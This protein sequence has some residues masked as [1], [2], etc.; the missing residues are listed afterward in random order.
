MA[1]EIT[2]ALAGNP[3]SGKTTVF[4]NLTGAHQHVGNWPGKTVEKKEGVCH[5]QGYRIK[6]VDL[7]GVYS[8]NAYSLDEIIARD[9][10]VEE[11]PDVVV[12]IVDTSNLERNLYLTVQL[13]EMEARLIIAFNMMDQA[14][15]RGYAIDVPRLSQL[16]GIP[17]V[18]MAAHRNLGTEELLREI[19]NVA[20]KKTQVKRL[21]IEYGREA[22][23]E[24]ANL[25]RLISRTELSRQYSPRWLVVK[26]LEEDEEIIRKFK[27][28]KLG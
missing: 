9:F 15:A 14:E 6:V 8:L 28:A 17:V 18:P 23:E 3:N 5:Y 1:E 2:I 12:D 19:V 11:K 7:P 22:E 4:N 25:E 10:I 26:L 24:I 21:R 20:E 13:L 27:E 16:L